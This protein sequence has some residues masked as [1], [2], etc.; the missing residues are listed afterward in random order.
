MIFYN[1]FERR[2]TSRGG[3]HISKAKE[4]PRETNRTPCPPWLRGGI[5]FRAQT[6]RPEHLAPAVVSIH[7]SLT[8]LHCYF[9]IFS[10][11]DCAC[12]NSSR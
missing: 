4:R 5:A 6:K 1:L 2:P 7:Y 11:I 12:V 9:V 8:T 3:S 10:P